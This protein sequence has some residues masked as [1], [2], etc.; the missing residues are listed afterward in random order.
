MSNCVI[1]NKFMCLT[2]RETRQKEILE[3]E[4]EKAL[5]QGDVLLMSKKHELFEV[6]SKIFF[7]AR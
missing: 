4:A 2:N 3:F 6:F 7:K 1:K 5:M